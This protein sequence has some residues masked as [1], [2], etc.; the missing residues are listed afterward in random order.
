ML[1][2]LPPLYAEIEAASV[3]GIP[4]RDIPGEDPRGIPPRGAPGEDP[5]PPV[6]ALHSRAW[7]PPAQ[8]AVRI[9]HA[10]GT[11]QCRIC[12]QCALCTGYGASCVKVR[13]RSRQGDAGQECGCG[14]GEE[15][16]T[17]CGVCKKCCPE[18]SRA[19]AAAAAAAAAAAMAS[20]GAAAL[21]KKDLQDMRTLLSFQALCALP[22]VR[23]VREL[24]AQRQAEAQGGQQLGSCARVP[25]FIRCVGNPLTKFS[26]E[27]CAAVFGDGPG[28]GGGRC[29]GV[30]TPV[31]DDDPR[32][33][34]DRWFKTIWWLLRTVHAD[35]RPVIDHPRGSAIPKTPRPQR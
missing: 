30:R 32:T 34:P 18:L 35:F 11:S 9:V 28:D 5:Q 15:G 16:C 4:P 7:P 10:I 1:G 23:A 31:Q 21:F 22:N 8:R 27:A 24:V 17:G 12:P 29:G 33:D 25:S 13:G 20:V 26:A 6:A 14:A 2:G 19:S 3:R